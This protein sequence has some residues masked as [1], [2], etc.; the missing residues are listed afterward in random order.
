MN[1]WVLWKM[2]WNFTG[3]S[4]MFYMTLMVSKTYIGRVC[5]ASNITNSTNLIINYIYYIFCKTVNSYIYTENFVCVIA[6][7]SFG[8]Y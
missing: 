5:G 3:I 7:K 4:I 8:W 1:G 2:F 6:W